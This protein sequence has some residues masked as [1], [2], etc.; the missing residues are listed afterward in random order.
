MKSKLAKIL[1]SFAFVV[2]CCFGFTAC[3]KTDAKLSSIKV[4]LVN[5]NYTMSSEVITKEFGENYQLKSSDF[6]VTAIFDDD[7]T[8]ELSLKTDTVDGFT[9][10]STIP[11]ESLDDGKT[12]IGDYVLTFG[13]ADIENV[14]IDFKV[15]KKTI[16]TSDLSWTYTSV[17]Y[18]GEFQSPKIE[19]DLTGVVNID[20]SSENDKKY[21]NEANLDYIATATL[22]LI[23]TEHYVLVGESTINCNWRIAK[24]TIDVPSISLV[25][26]NIA[27]PGSEPVT[28]RADLSETNK[29]ELS[30]KHISYDIKEIIDGGRISKIET[31]NAGT[32][33]VEIVLTY[34]GQGDT[35]EEKSQDKISYSG[36]SPMQLTWQV[37]EYK[38]QLP[39]DIQFVTKIGEV[40]TDIKNCDFVYNGENYS[41]ALKVE[42]TD[43]EDYREFINIDTYQFVEKNAGTYT[44]TVRFSVKEDYQNNYILSYYEKSVTWT[45]SKPEI[46]P[47]ASTDY[48]LGNNLYDDE[49]DNGEWNLYVLNTNT[50]F[51]IGF[52]EKLI[53]GSTLKYGDALNIVYGVENAS[54]EVEEYN[55]SLTLTQNAECIVYAKVSL[56]QEHAENIDFTEQFIKF[57][58]TVQGHYFKMLRLN[59]EDISYSDLL[60]I[61]TFKVYDVVEFSLLS[62]FEYNIMSGDEDV[63]TE[64]NI[65]QM[66][67]YQGKNFVISLKSNSEKI[68]ELNSIQLDTVQTISVN[69]T[70]CSNCEFGGSSQVNIT[71]DMAEITFVIDKET[72]DSYCNGNEESG[73]IWIKYNRAE[74][75]SEDISEDEMVYSVTL[76]RFALTYDREAGN[77]VVS[78]SISQ[79]DIGR[80]AEILIGYFSDGLSSS[81]FITMYTINLTKQD[82]AGE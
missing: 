7:S 47:L 43:F 65:Y 22:S 51:S 5:D 58:I 64:N 1:L 56:K 77:Y 35:D 49:F 46:T 44:K 41:I 71:D 59:G 18:N 21:V 13:Y 39:E 79:S 70:S 42:D 45:I 2:L 15:T 80:N 12:P 34:D 17:V 61:T 74:S 11:T 6:K 55:N 30:D 40:K 20:Y 62:D 76:V 81:E 4:E 8:K 36:L 72:F 82:N 9:F 32:Y 10:S 75:N 31:E 38:I 29:Q 25:N 52:G 19:Q 73:N 69:E 60:A 28:F 37:F 27:G 68:F 33:W 24:A 57:N 63:S 66:Y 23:D 16:N 50:N 3:K 14:D 54:G 78:C 26:Y 53:S 48:I 67:Q